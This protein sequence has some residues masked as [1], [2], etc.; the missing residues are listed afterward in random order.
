MIFLSKLKEQKII[1]K[2]SEKQ[3]HFIEKNMTR[4]TNSRM[5]KLSEVKAFLGAPF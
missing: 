5:K 2:N 3:L 4:Y 1:V